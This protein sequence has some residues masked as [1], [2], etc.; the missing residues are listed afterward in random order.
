M[1]KYT[2]S[3][4][5][6]FM[7]FLFTAVDRSSASHGAEN[8]AGRRDR[9]AHEPSSILGLEAQVLALEMS[10]L[11]V[12]CHLLH[13]ISTPL[14]GGHEVVDRLSIVRRNGILLS[15]VALLDN[16]V[17]KLKVSMIIQVEEQEGD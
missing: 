15:E 4:L 13:G 12:L 5:L 17:G 2:Q 6:F 11:G 9:H 14:V 8:L 10:S 3:I 1:S 16:R 7:I